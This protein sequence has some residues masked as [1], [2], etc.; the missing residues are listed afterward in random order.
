[1]RIFVISFVCFLCC[2]PILA[3]KQDSIALRSNNEQHTL[4]VNGQEFFIKGMNWDYFPTGTNYSYSLWKQPDATIKAALDYEM[5]LL[6]NMGVNVIRQYTG[7]PSRWISYIH[8]RFGIYTVLNHTFGRY[9]LTVNNA[10]VP[11]ID[12]ANAE[13]QSILLKEVVEMVSQ[14]KNTPGLLM[15]LLGN[16]NNYGLFW[17]GAE[18]EDIPVKDKQ[19]TKDAV[20]MYRLFNK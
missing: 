10:W 15:Y 16:E 4:V 6:K 14:Y 11:N 8:E 9:G 7:I 20:Q 13:I 2:C 12:Y 5:G 3:A 18:T 1:M 17:R 19:S